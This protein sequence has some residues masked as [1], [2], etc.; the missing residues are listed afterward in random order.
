MNFN[1]VV[2]FAFHMAVNS[3]TCKSTML[4]LGPPG[5]G[6]TSIGAELAIRLEQHYKAPVDYYAQD[7][8][9]L[10]PE[11]L[12]GVPV[13]DPDG[14]AVAYA[15]D[16]WL[17]ECCKPG[18]RRVLILDDLPAAAPTVV[19]ACRQLVLARLMHTHKLSDGVFV[20]VTGNR[21][22]DKT[23]A[24]VMPSHFINAVHQVVLTPE[25][26]QWTTWY[27]QQ[28]NA[29][30]LIPA[31]LQHS[32]DLF[33]KGPQDP[34]INAAGTNGAFPTPRQ[35]ALLGNMLNALPFHYWPTAAEGVIGSVAAQKFYAYASVH[36]L[37]PDTKAVIKHG[38]MK[39]LQDFFALPMVADKSRPDL[40][41]ACISALIA[42]W[43]GADPKM[44]VDSAKPEITGEYG[45][46]FC[47]AAALIAS[48]VGSD[49]IG[50]L[51]VL[52]SIIGP[53]TK[54]TED[55]STGQE[56]FLRASKE[57]LAR[58]R[59]TANNTAV[60]GLFRRIHELYKI[61][62]EDGMGMSNA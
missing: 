20:I 42:E 47:L 43:I 48:S 55:R 58:N 22:E 34:A 17:A 56:L 7:L 23:G 37:L 9:S 31:F 5:I 50:M 24:R 61:S 27:R 4:I 41:H 3:E 1:E 49:Y 15:A 25:L 10:L 38:D 62:V 26:S 8:T 30:W 54:Y 2:D 32:P 35:W 52:T 36:E 46:N 21:P 18:K 45:N 44:T 14:Q 29:H 28:R 12:T 39:P 53:N 59:L 33:C 51:N 11:D 13:I 6:K 19:I 40:V 16:A 60:R 57:A